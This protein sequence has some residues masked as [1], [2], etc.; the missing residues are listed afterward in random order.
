MLP[1]EYIIFYTIRSWKNS[2][3]RVTHE[4]YREK[5]DQ[6]PGKPPSSLSCENENKL[7]INQ[8]IE[9][10]SDTDSEDSDEI[11]NTPQWKEAKKILDQEQPR[12]SPIFNL[13]TS[14]MTDA[15]L[16]IE[17]PNAIVMKSVEQNHGDTIA[18][19]LKRVGCST[20]SFGVQPDE[21]RE[22]LDKQFQEKERKAARHA[23]DARKKTAADRVSEIER[24]AKLPLKQQFE[25][26]ANEYPLKKSRWMAWKV[27]MKMA[28]RNELPNISILLRSI[29]NHKTLD[30]SWNKDNGRWIPAL[31]K[32]LRERRWTDQP[33]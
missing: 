28:N 20:F 23:E 19:A 24:L 17:G 22:I 30:S 16:I 9:E 21:I 6:I 14:R 31:P 13:L 26:L 27:F 8:T 4:E 25:L 11:G 18:N 12:L 1:A 32:W 10:N 15:G 3:K 29:R 33:S 5:Q 7:F 2:K